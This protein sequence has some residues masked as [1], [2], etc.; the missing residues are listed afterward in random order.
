M[1]KIKIWFKGKMIN[2]ADA[3]I[4]VLSPAAQF[5][6]NVFEGIRC[7]WSSENE[8]LYAFRLHDHLIRLMESTKL[9]RIPCPYDLDQM[10]NYFIESVAS[11]DLKEN[12]AVRMT[13]FVDGEGTWHSEECSSLFISPISVNKNNLEGKS[14]CISSWER[15]NDNSMPP[16]VKCGANYISGRYS[17]LDAK[18]S[19]FDLPIMLNNAGHIAEG[20]GACIF[21]VRNNKLITPSY[22]SSILESITRSTIVKFAEDL[23]MDVTERDVGRTELYI[24]DEIFLCGSA[25]EITPILAVDNI[26]IGLGVVGPV[27]KILYDRYLDIVTGRIEKHMDWLTPIYKK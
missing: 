3:S 23:G 19:G 4:S 26:E 20:A 9:M 14:A 1:N 5:G 15:I 16:R 27:T 2:R 22:A 13:L 6:L 11:N 12:I 8:E 25:A 18:K 7:Y 24:S 17:H 10:K 21:I